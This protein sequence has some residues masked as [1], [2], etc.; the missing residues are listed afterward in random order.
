M[1]R[2]HA[3]RR[4][5]KSRWLLAA[6]GAGLG[7]ATLELVM[8]VV[9]FVLWSRL[10]AE[11]NAAPAAADTTLLCVGDSFTYGLGASERSRSYPA[12][13]QQRL[14]AARPGAFAVVNRG[15]PGQASAD[16]VR[17]LDRALASLRPRTVYLLIGCNDR[18]SV[19]P[20]LAAA[21][22]V[23][24][25]DSGFE[26]KL[27]TLALLRR[28]AGALGP[29]HAAAP[30]AQPRLELPGELCGTWHAGALEVV[31]DSDGRAEV[32]GVPSQW[33]VEGG[34]LRLGSDDARQVLAWQRD[35]ERLVLEGASIAAGRLVLERGPA[36]AEPAA[37][38][39]DLLR[40]GDLAAASARLPEVSPEARRVA[41]AVELAHRA[42]DR[43]GLERGLVRLDALAAL[44]DEGRVERL[45]AW[46][47]IGRSADGVPGALAAIE[48]EPTRAELW[49]AVIDLLDREPRWRADVV[50]CVG[51]VIAARPAGDPAL[52]VLFATRAMLEG[53]AGGD[54]V[55]ALA[56]G[57][58][59]GLL[60]GDFG[61]AVAALRSRPALYDERTIA[62]ARARL[63][64]TPEQERRVDEVLLR[65]SDD[66]RSVEERLE[67]HV[68]LCA[69]R[70]RHHAAELVLLLY[71]EPISIDAAV[72]RAADRLG[73]RLVD[74]QPRFR[75]ALAR[76]RR[77]DYF[78]WDGHCSDA[79]YALLADVVAADV[80]DAR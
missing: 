30:N 65:S 72:R 62:A 17:R 10:E 59:A 77:A 60:N 51:R 71:P 28:I 27:R 44:D 16:V 7:I 75:A 1:D 15:V 39:R 45:R 8:Q 12:V 73:V 64:L 14:D 4:R 41:L 80:L 74:P 54:P 34:E 32:G 53:R 48:A 50:A 33:S 3:P 40:A 35:G 38:V 79:G 13:L 78:V 36:A 52:A 19:A 9:A 11:R 56:D 61:H 26:W 20:A 70:C 42:G 69:E 57:L 25:G 68:S 47:A 58:Q 49:S 29:G 6:A 24:A 22:A 67:W 18:W 66:A 55:T 23:G 5:R 2:P 76:G 21:D 46:L 31:L 37:A 43:A 63:V